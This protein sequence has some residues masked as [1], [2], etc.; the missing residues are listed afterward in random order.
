MNDKNTQEI[1]LTPELVIRAYEAGI[2]PMSEDEHSSGVF[3]VSPDKRGIIPLENFHISKSLLKEIKKNKYQIRID[4][5][6][7]AIIHGCANFGTERKTTWINSDIINVYRQLFKQKICHTIEV[8]DK[9]QLIGG[10]YGLALNGAFFGESMFHT[11]SNA[12]K[13]ALFCLIKRL[14]FGGYSLLDTQFITPHLAS[15]GAIEIEREEYETL[16]FQSQHIKADFYRLS[17]GN[18]SLD[19]LQSSSHTS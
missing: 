11:V 13:I 19:C 5:D 4:N 15:L 7:D 9:N 16:L 6:F 18:T 14:Q 12:S 8:W 10:L 3:W 17:G 1:E 2:F